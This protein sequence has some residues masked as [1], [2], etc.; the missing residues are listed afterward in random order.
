MKTIKTNT[1]IPVNAIILP[2]CRPQLDDDAHLIHRLLLSPALHTLLSA[3][4]SLL[5]PDIIGKSN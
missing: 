3:M 5:I 1:T 4:E 2:L